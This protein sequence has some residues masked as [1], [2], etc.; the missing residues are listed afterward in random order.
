[1]LLFW[2]HSI[3]IKKGV[4][5]VKLPQIECKIVTILVQIEHFSPHIYALF[6]QILLRQKFTR[7]L[8]ALQKNLQHNCIKTSQ[9]QKDKKGKKKK[10]KQIYIKDKKQSV[11]KS[12]R[13]R[14]ELALVNY[15]FKE[16]AKCTKKCKVQGSINK[17]LV[18]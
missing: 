11:Q 16:K 12:V 10:G 2:Q 8:T 7:F 1:M 15:T 18:I 5:R 3:Y 6:C 14:D 17:S 9:L 13:C 4:L